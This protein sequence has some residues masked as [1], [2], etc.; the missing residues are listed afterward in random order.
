MKKLVIYGASF[1]DV[2]KLVDAI[3]RSEPAWKILGYLDDNKN[4]HARSFMGYNV[5]GGREMIKDLSS[6]QDVCFFVNISSN[7]KT[8]KSITDMLDLIKCNIVSLIHPAVD[9]NYVQIGRGCI[10]PEGCI[11][12]GNVKIG[13]FVFLRLQSLVSH[14]VTVED[15]VFIGAG[16]N[17]S[18]NVVLERGCYIGAGATIMRKLTIGESAI[19][20]A[21]AVVTKDVPPRSTVAGVPAKILQN[22]NKYFL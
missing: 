19:V 4:M 22:N 16:V 11:I 7:W 12:G 1:F 2:I 10:I 9:V 21:G 8:L 20:G 13:D 15:F 14:D 6:Q 3:N 18:S 17:I 5:L